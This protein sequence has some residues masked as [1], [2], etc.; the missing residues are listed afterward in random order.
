[1]EYKKIDDYKIAVLDNIPN[2]AIEGKMT[3][4][5]DFLNL[6][7]F[8][9]FGGD[10]NRGGF[11][12]P[13]NISELESLKGAKMAY[14]ELIKRGG[15]PPKIKFMEY[16]EKDSA[17]AKPITLTAQRPPLKRRQHGNPGV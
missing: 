6:I 2:K 14:E 13:K 5:Y 16:A 10:E 8:Y 11:T 15:K 1:M 3:Q 17:T 9:Y 7:T 12:D 4:V